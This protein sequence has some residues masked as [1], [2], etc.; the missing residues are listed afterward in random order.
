MPQLQAHCK[1]LTKEGRSADCRKFINS[2]SQLLNS[3]TLWCSNDGTGQN[4]SAEQRDKETRLLSNN[5][6][7]LEDVSSPIVISTKASAPKPKPKP[8]IVRGCEWYAALGAKLKA[9]A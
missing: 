1:E 6:K 5:L 2:W 4:L 7:K 8:H 9:L 3:L